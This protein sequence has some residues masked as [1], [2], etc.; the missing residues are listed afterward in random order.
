[1][2]RKGRKKT[3]RDDD[4]SL[5]EMMD[6]QGTLFVIEQHPVEA[7]ATRTKQCTGA[8]LMKRDPEAYQ[9]IVE[10]LA[11]GM[12][13][14]QIKKLWGVGTQTVYAVLRRENLKVGTLKDRIATTLYLG[15]MQAAEVAADLIEDCDDPVQAAMAAKMLLETGNLMKGQATAITES[16]VVVVDATKA[17]AD[18]MARAEEMGLGAAG[19]NALSASGSDVA[20]PALDLASGL[21]EVLPLD[22]QSNVNGPQTLEIQGSGGSCH[23][24]C[25]QE[26]TTGPE[27]EP[28][29]GGG[30][31]ASGDAST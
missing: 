6:A 13:M 9:A 3:R 24:P 28:R 17:A 15:G 30:R 21:V 1:M 19:K 4:G 7:E 2:S 20:A 10:A 11:S 27:N 5:I 26:G 14:R 25:N 31:A 16:R 23:H 22:S 8:L 29:G 12:P 18:L